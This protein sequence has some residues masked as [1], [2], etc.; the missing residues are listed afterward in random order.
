MAW[1]AV[2]A[3]FLALL[4]DPAVGMFQSFDIERV[5]LLATA[6]QSDDAMAWHANSAVSDCVG[7]VPNNLGRLKDHLTTNDVFR[8]AL[9]FALEYVARLELVVDKQVRRGCKAG[10][11]FRQRHERVVF[12]QVRCGPDGR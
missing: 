3:F 9:G 2:R 12:Q 7:F 11:R 1:A 8:K 10:F 5:L 4:G 6:L